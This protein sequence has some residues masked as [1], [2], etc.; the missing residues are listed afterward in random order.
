M[1]KYIHASLTLYLVKWSK[2]SLYFSKP[3][4]HHI[5]HFVDGML[6]TGFITVSL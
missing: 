2:L 4:L 5:K 1:I 6:S 3:V